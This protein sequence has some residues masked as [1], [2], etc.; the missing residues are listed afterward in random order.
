MKNTLK[1]HVDECVSDVLGL[2]PVDYLGS[3]YNVHVL[4]CYCK[5]YGISLETL[6]DVELK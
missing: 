5:E 4:D 2:P 3:E 6:I 1:H